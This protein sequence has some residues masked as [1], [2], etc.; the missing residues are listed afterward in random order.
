MVTQAQP[1]RLVGVWPSMSPRRPPYYRVP[2]DPDTLAGFLR[3]QMLAREW[4]Q[5]QL[6]D[7]SGIPQNRISNYVRGEHR[8]PRPE[9]LEK[10]DE[11][12]GLPR[13]TFHGKA[14]GDGATRSGESP[15]PGSLVIPPND[16]E[17]VEL[18]EDVLLLHGDRPNQRRLRRAL[19]L[20]LGGKRTGRSAYPNEPVA[21]S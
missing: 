6:A 19:G 21:E 9:T 20:I 17:L 8:Y 7:V 18:V 12:F 2:I 15:E 13:G 5:T 4:N 16:P 10:L 14:Y 11:A 1:I 3:Q